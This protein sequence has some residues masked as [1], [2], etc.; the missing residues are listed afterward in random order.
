MTRKRTKKGFTLI[1]L[2][3]VLAIFSIIMALVMSFIDPVARLMSRTSIKERTAAYVD[4]IDE[5]IENSIHYAKYVRVFEGGYCDVADD[6]AALSDNT[7][8]GVAQNF[9]DHFLNR[10]VDAN[11]DPIK[12]KVRILKLIN[13]SD[14]TL[15]AGRIYESVFDFT[16]K[17]S[18]DEKVLD[19]YE[20]DGV[21]PIYKFVN[22]E[23]SPSTVTATSITNRMVLNEEHFEDYNYYYRLGF[24]NFVPVPNGTIPGK[25]SEARNYY[26]WLVP[27]V[28]TDSNPIEIDR[29]AGR[30]FSLNVVAYQNGNKE[31]VTY[32]D[33]TSDVNTTIFKSPAHMSTAS[34]AFINAIKAN[35]ADSAPY[36]K[37]QY[38]N[39]GHV[40]I[41]EG[42]KVFEQIS[43]VDTGLA[44]RVLSPAFASTDNIYIVYILPEEIYDTDTI[45]N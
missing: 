7:D 28:G 41:N 33:G 38:D 26:N 21:T 13:T 8:A 31:D 30:N 5:Y 6:T 39:T 35:E 11:G 40:K 15:E 14:G 44:F 10:V 18:W 37:L 12:G 2:I 23:I 29:T 43:S 22:H 3:I 4:N 32:N 19:G 20:I 9:V 24:F 16:A 17:A 1:E 42:K 25:T 36:Y 45:Y 27:M 34:M